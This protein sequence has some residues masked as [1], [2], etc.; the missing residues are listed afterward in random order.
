VTELA[1]YAALVVLTGVCVAR[2]HGAGPPLG[3]ALAVLV[4]MLAGAAVPG[5]LERAARTLWRPFLTLVSIM[6]ITAAAQRLGILD[7]VAA[8]VEPRTR[9]PVKHA[10]RI[11]F[12]VSA[13]AAAVLSN[14]A[15]ILLVT[16]T[17]MTLLRAVY[18][19]RHPKFL[20]PFAFAVFAA[21][22]VAPLVISNPMN[23]V[24]AGHAGIGFNE[25]ALRMVP[26]AA[27]GWLVA[28][29]VLARLFK[30]VLADV[31][32]ALGEW[33]PSS[34]RLSGAGRVVLVILVVV[35]G[36]YPVVSYLGGPLWLVSLAG[37][38]GCLVTC[39]AARVPATEL[40]RAVSWNVLPFLFGVFVLAL[41]LERAGLVERLAWLYGA[42]PAPL[43]TIGGVAAGGSALLNNHPMALLNAL[44]IERVPGAGHTEVLAALVGG[45]L[46]P[47][48]L[49]MGSL[50]GILWMDVLRRQGVRVSVGTFARVGAALTLPTLVVSLLTLWLL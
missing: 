43:A 34:A 15:A 12:V 13:L 36:A 33:T 41:G 7:R 50:A 1:S 42:S 17:V 2:P 44:A 14:D 19:K 9:K 47:R 20:L 30:G 29:L 6:T 49:P 25:Y 18:P 23:L 45:D 48:L 28:Y 22:G 4:A 16:P 40:A 32:P 24:V 8:I 5:D 26:V 10:F 27:V 35:L 21:A 38:A 46:G 31:D 3:A 37:A 11:T 39:A